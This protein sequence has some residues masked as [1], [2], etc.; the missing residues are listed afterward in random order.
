[1]KEK[2]DRTISVN[3]SVKPAHISV[4]KAPKL[5]VNGTYYISFGNHEAAPCILLDVMD[6]HKI[7]VGLK[8]NS[9]NGYG[10][11]YVVLNRE[12]GSSPEEAVIN[13][14]ISTV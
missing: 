13:E 7:R 9:K 3:K 2:N 11:V 4:R 6:N 1:M 8:N 14:Q 10:D 5:V 12:I